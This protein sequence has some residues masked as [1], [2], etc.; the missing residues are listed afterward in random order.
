MP[1]RQPWSDISQLKRGFHRWLN[2]VLESGCD[3][4]QLWD[5]R[6]GC[7]AGAG[8]QHWLGSSPEAD[9]P[10]SLDTQVRGLPSGACH[11][12]WYTTQEYGN[13]VP[14]DEGSR[15]KEEI[16]SRQAGEGRPGGGG[17]RWSKVFTGW[18][19]FKQAEMRVSICRQRNGYVQRNSVGGP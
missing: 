12:V 11:P 18:V 4:G 17:W 8:P 5:L 14:N 10:G 15:E 16:D 2:W 1:I 6:Q 19:G 13:R 7:R 9:T 3:V